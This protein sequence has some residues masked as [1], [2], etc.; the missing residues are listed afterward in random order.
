MYFIGSERRKTTNVL[1]AFWGVNEP[2][3]FLYSSLK[4]IKL[5]IIHQIKHYN[6]PHQL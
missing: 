4:L 6:A 3:S 5:I 2:L 1:E